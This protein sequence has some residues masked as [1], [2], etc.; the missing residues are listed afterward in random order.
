MLLDHRKDQIVLAN[1]DVFNLRDAITLL[2]DSD[3]S[4]FAELSVAANQAAFPLTGESTGIYVADD[5]EKLY[6]WAGS[7]Y[8][9]IARGIDTSGLTLATN[10]FLQWNGSAWTN[11]QL[12]T[13]IEDGGTGTDVSGLLYGDGAGKQPILRIGIG[14]YR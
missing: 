13:S 1:G 4:G 3:P 5:T 2:G 10:D 12:S 9:E 7:E 6:R 8:V 11:V 14:R